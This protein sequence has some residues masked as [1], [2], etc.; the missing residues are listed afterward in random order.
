MRRIVGHV[1]LHHTYKLIS[2]MGTKTCAVWP[3]L[4]HELQVL[5]VILG[6]SLGVVLALPQHPAVAPLAENLCPKPSQRISL[7]IIDR[8][9]MS[10][11]NR[12][13]DLALWRVALHLVGTLRPCS[14]QRSRSKTRPVH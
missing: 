1:E 8:S 5:R 4:R 9:R 7:Y 14:P 11:I 10:S 2:K 6:D 12:S 3:T 13:S